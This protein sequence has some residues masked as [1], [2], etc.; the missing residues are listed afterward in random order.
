[1]FQ[2]VSKT[3][4]ELITLAKQGNFDELYVK[5]SKFYDIF[6]RNNKNI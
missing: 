5:F 6:I 1:M 4:K 2:D 3:F